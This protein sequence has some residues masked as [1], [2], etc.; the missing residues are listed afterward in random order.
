[1][2][3][4]PKLDTHD[5]RQSAYR[6]DA[7]VDGRGRQDP[8]AADT[9]DAAPPQEGQPQAYYPRGHGHGGGLGEGE[10]DGH[11]ERDGQTQPNFGQSGTYGKQDHQQAQQR[12]RAD[13]DSD[14]EGDDT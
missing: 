12:A 1:M 8:S 6:G 2:N 13:S 9:A 5:E 4:K 3:D 14:S 7:S 10:P 11:A